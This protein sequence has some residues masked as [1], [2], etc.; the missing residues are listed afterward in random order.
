MR[1]NHGR[2]DRLHDRL[3]AR[4][5]AKL[6]LRAWKQG[7]DEDPWVTLT[8]PDHQAR[9]YNRLITLMNGVNIRLG[10]LIAV[11]YEAGLVLSQRLGW[12]STIVL[13]EAN[14]DSVRLFLRAHVKRPITESEY[15][16]QARRARDEL[17][18][19]A[20]LAEEEADNNEDWGPEDVETGEDGEERVSEAAW[21]RVKKERIKALRQLVREGELEGRKTGKGLAIRASSYYGRR[22]EDVPVLWDCDGFAGVEMLPDSRAEEVERWRRSQELLEESME[23]LGDARGGS[24]DGSD[25]RGLREIIEDKIKS[26]LGYVWADLW[27]ATRVIDEVAAEFDGEDPLLPEVRETLREVRERLEELL[28]GIKDRLGGLDLPEPDVEMMEELRTAAG[29]PEPH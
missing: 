8:M 6:V 7:K 12:L 17:I 27:A 10:A 5:R 24:G 15:A 4:E 20:E 3:T 2:L 11:H 29:L 25:R 1:T 21:E 9:E 18:P 28:Q 22:G 13:Y 19:V 26:E 14:M 16:E 23:R